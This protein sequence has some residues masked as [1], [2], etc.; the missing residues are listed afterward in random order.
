MLDDSW[1]NLKIEDVLKRLSTRESGLTIS[2]AKSRLDKYGFN[3]LE[4]I[5]SRS[6]ILIFLKQFQ[7]PLIYILIIAGLITLFLADY[8]DSIVIISVVIIN[9]SIGVIQEYKAE[10][11][12]EKLS[13]MIVPKARILREGREIE[14]NSSHVVPGDVALLTSG[15]RVS[16]DMRLISVNELKVD[17]ST[18]TGESVPVEKIVE[19]IL[20]RNIMPGDQKNMAFAGTTV[21]SGR[22]RAVVVATGKNTELGKISSDMKTAVD[23]KT[24]LMAKMGS[25]SKKVGI[26]VLFV[27]AIMVMLG[28]YSG[29]KISEILY[30]AVAVAVGVI[31][32]GLPAIVSITLAVGVTRMARH[33]AIIRKLPAVETLGSATI[34]ASDKTGTLTK[35]EMTVKKIS[36]IERLYEVTGNGYDPIGNFSSEGVEIKEDISLDLTLKIGM[37]C[38]ES[39]IYQEKGIWKIDG[40][41]TEGALIVA[42]MK[43]GFDPEK[44]INQYPILDTVPFESERGYMATLHENNGKKIVFVKGSVEKIFNMFRSA[45]HLDGEVEP[46]FGENLMKEAQKL[47]LE[48][49]RVLSMAYKEMP[50][51]TSEITHKQIEVD[52]LIFAGFQAMIDPPRPEAIEAIRKA[53]N[54]GIRV[55]MITGDYSITAKAIAEQMGII[56]SGGTVLTGRELE[57]ITDEELCQKLREVSVFA[58]VSPNHKL[59][60]VKALQ[61]NGDIVAVTGDGVNDAPALKVA[62]IGVSMGESGTDVA[63]DASDMVLTDDNFANIYRAVIEGRIVF[64]NIR[65]VTQFLIAPAF[66]LIMTVLASYLLR[67]PFPFHP[68]QLL[69]MNLVTNGLQDIALCFEKGEKDIE[70]RPPRNPKDGILSNYFPRFIFTGVVIMIILLAIFLW[71]LNIGATLD[72][73]RTAA[74][75]GIVCLQF[76]YAFMSRSENNTIFEISPFSNKLLILTIAGAFTAQF[77]AIYHPSFQ[78]ILKTDS[79]SLTTFLI[80]LIASSSILIVE[81]EKHFRK[82]MQRALE[83]EKA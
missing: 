45:C 15:M 62:Q 49:L 5:K 26:A 52:G 25:L 10:R 72:H 56:E 37:V 40:D 64:D 21:S 82:N 35:N 74:L 73:A 50:P 30:H 76:F 27:S 24:P 43:R 39:S 16:A 59:R 2:E 34:I 68:I 65:K 17:E 31:P 32:E 60:I 48:G 66:G 19:P 22:G 38:N 58:R 18:L 7:N 36:T 80:I 55:I 9:A 8:V 83:D 11:S 13:R 33:E 1:F 44:I 75:T 29:E 67:I 61:K 63:R 3:Q 46:C 81:I 47:A 57:G 12:I 28:I 6:P 54:S 79:I 71:Q 14:V 4:E 42:G 53:K 77:L 70:L 78:Y 51:E 41:P 23:V 69:W 20:V